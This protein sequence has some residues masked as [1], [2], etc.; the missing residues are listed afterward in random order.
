MCPSIERGRED[1]ERG[2]FVWFAFAWAADASWEGVRAAGLLGA[3]EG[4][5]EKKGERVSPDSREDTRT[6][7]RGFGPRGGGAGSVFSGRS[8]CVVWLPSVFFFFR[9]A[10]F[11]VLSSLSGVWG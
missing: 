9:A 5:L 3:M 11:G 1:L 2:K 7:S 4:F 8:C 10:I 6:R